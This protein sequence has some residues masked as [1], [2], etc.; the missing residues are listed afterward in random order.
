M[1]AVPVSIRRRDFPMCT[2]KPV[3]TI[4]YALSGTN[5][6]VRA[7]AAGVFIEG[8]MAALTPSQRDRVALL[9]RLAQE[10]HR[11]LKAGRVPSASK[12]PSWIDTTEARRSA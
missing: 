7:T 10:R 8:D 5:V 12:E 9:E 3:T 11:S 4:R 6:A 1:G 2:T